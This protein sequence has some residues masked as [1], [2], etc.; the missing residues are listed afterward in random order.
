MDSRLP[1]IVF[2]V[3]TA[4]AAIY[5][6]LQYGRLPGIVALHFNGRGEPNG[7]E[8]KD[9]FFAVFAGAVSV[10]AVLTF[11]VPALTK[12]LPNALINLPHK[13]QWLS[14]E[15]RM[16][17][18]EFMSAWFAWFGCAVLV[19]IL[20]AFVYALQSNT[21]PGHPPDPRGFLYILIGFG[22][23]TVTWMVRFLTKFARSPQDMAR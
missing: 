2:L 15:R 17:T 21:N 19:V 7:W 1:K 16:A 3:L 23:F 5:F 9:V 18:L 12:I 8:A 22:I 13:E 14:P 10:A 6:R 4:F 11:G 20:L